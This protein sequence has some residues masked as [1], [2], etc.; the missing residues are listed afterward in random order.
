MPSKNSY[1]ELI[2]DFQELLR[3]TEAT[4]DLLP[5]IEAERQVLAQVV[6]EVESLRTRQRE[7]TAQKQRASQ[8]LREAIE[9][10]K[11]ASIQVRSV[12]RGK[13]GPKNELLTQFRVA[14]LRKRKRKPAEDEEKPSGENPGTNDG[15]PASPPDKDAA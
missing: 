8:Q 7:L 15:T 10:G 13:V 4:P 11:E 12:L 14:P 9:R 2:I 6:A 3:S 1:T 5:A